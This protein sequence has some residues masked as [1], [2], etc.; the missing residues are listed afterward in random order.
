MFS[1]QTKVYTVVCNIV[2]GVVLGGQPIFGYNYGAGKMDRVRQTYRMVLQ[3]TL[4]VGICA[5]LLFELWP[6]GIIAI[7]GSGDA[8]Y[9]EFAVKTFRIYLS[10]TVIT[11]LVKMTAIFFQSIGKSIRAIVASLI[12]DILCFTPL[13]LALPVLLENAEPG[14]GINGIL[15]AAPISDFVAAG[16]ILLLTVPFFRQLKKQETAERR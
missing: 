3:T 7:F 12:R 14:S 1:I 6:Q 11:C 10:L 2:V 16:V 9:Q 8:L 5:T 15:V 4:I 13:A